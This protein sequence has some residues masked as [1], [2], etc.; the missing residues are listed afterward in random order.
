MSQLWPDGDWFNGKTSAQ[1]MEE[2]RQ[3]I[4]GWVKLTTTRG[5]GEYDSPCIAYGVYLLP[6]VLSGRPGRKDPAMKLKRGRR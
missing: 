5:Q 3:W 6:H 2:A 1:N 4:E